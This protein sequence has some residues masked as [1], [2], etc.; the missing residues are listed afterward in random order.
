[1]IYRV[2]DG[3]GFHAT[4]PIH[5]AMSLPEPNPG[6]DPDRHQRMNGPD[7]GIWIDVTNRFVK[8]GAFDGNTLTESGFDSWLRDSNNPY[9]HRRL[10][11]S[12][13]SLRL[14]LLACTVAATSNRILAHVEIRTCQ[15]LNHLKSR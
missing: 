14:T 8:F 3:K 4:E 11:S 15:S 10:P 6:M 1:M 7:F 9:T 5:N 12:Q 2:R 13:R